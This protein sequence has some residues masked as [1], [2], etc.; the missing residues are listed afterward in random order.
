MSDQPAAGSPQVESSS[1]VD[2]PDSS[3]RRAATIWAD[4]RLQLGCMVGHGARLRPF[5]FCVMQTP[6]DAL[7]HSESGD[8]ASVEPSPAVRQ[9]QTRAAGQAFLAA[10]RA[11][12]AALRADLAALLR[13]RR[14]GFSPARNR[15]TPAPRSI[16]SINRM[17]RP[18]SAFGR[19]IRGIA[20]GIA[21]TGVFVASMAAGAMFWAL[22][23]L[24]PEMPVGGSETA[25]LLE[26]ANGQ[27][28]GRVGPLRT[29]D[30]A[31]ADFP[32]RLVN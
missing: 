1:R 9:S 22:H 30:A 12:L 24:P 31:R 21:L 4:G 5:R 10:L 16:N 19:A 14:R 17:T 15:T 28:L 23:D 6:N 20:A 32:D 18:G 3:P 2:V 26:A 25:L 13:R 7:G 29:T 27:A 11:D 8:A